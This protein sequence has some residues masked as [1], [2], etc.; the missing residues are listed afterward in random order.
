M[1]HTPGPWY[2]V[3]YAGYINIQTTDDYSIEDDVLDADIIGYDQMLVNG[4]LA[5]AAP[6]MYE[7]LKRASAMLVS[8]SWRKDYNQLLNRIDH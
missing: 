1:K 7:L 5:A 3:E 8:E 6:E 2:A 4:N